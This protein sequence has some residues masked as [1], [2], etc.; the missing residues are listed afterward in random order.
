M[1]GID[2]IE[3]IL[4]GIEEIQSLKID[5]V[6]NLTRIQQYIE[7]R[8]KELDLGIPFTS[9]EAEKTRE[10]EHMID[11]LRVLLKEISDEKTEGGPAEI[12][13]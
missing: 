6:E 12:G 5:T 8:V 9:E 3:E 10:V 4:H 2:D 13:T 1:C 7:E 11:K